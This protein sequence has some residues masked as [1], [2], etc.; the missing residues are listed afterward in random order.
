MCV[1]GVGNHF[2]KTFHFQSISKMDSV[3]ILAEKGGKMVVQRS[4]SIENPKWKIVSFRKIVD[5]ARTKL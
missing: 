5:E 4:M 1:A 2:N 3:S